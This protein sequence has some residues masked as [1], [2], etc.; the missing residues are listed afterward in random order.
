MLLLLMSG[1]IASAA[2]AQ[3]Q[4]GMKHDPK[5]WDNKVKAELNLSADQQTKYDEVSKEYGARMDA[6]MKD[7]SLSKEVQKERKMDLKKEKQSKLFEI[8]T[9]EQQSKYKDMIEKKKAMKPADS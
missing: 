6:V 1:L 8:F 2:L 9:P 5:E 7:A 3:D 4:K